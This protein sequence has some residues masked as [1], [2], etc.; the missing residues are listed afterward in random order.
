MRSFKLPPPLPMDSC[1]SDAERPAEATAGTETGGG[2][3]A[4]AEEA[5]GSAVGRGLRWNWSGLDF[6]G[7]GAAAGLLNMAKRSRKLVVGALPSAATGAVEAGAGCGCVGAS[8]RWT[9][10]AGT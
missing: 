1:A 5:G 8:P 7:G 3:G 10:E 4:A 6:M 2:V 9:K